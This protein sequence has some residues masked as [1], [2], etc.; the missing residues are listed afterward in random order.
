MPSICNHVDRLEASGLVTRRQGERDR[1]RV[2]LEVTAE[3]IRVLQAIRSKRTAWLSARLNALTDVGPRRHRGRHRAARGAPGAAGMSLGIGSATA[4]TFTS[5][6]RHYNYRLYFFGQVVSISGTWMQSVAQAWFVVQNTHSPL[7]VGI[8]AVC[9]FG[10]YALLGLFG[11]AVAD[12]LDQRKVLLGTQA[13][14]MITATLLAVLTLTGHATV[15]EVYVIAAI[16]GTITVVDNPVR[17]AFTIQMVGRDELPNAVALNSSLFNA[18]RIVGPAIAGGLIA[19][20]GVG[21]CFLINALSY[22]AVLAALWM[23]RVHDL[24]PTTP[25]SASSEPVPRIDRGSE[26]RVAHTGDPLGAR[27]DAVHRDDQHQLQRA[28]A[29]PRIANAA[30]RSAGLR[31]PLGTVRIRRAPWRPLLGLAGSCEPA[32]HARRR[33]ALLCSPSLYSR[34]STSSGPRASHS[35]G[36]GHRVHASTP[37]QTNATLQLAVTDQLRGRVLGIYGYVFFGTAPTRWPPRRA[38]S[39]QSAGPSWRSWSPALTGARRDHLRVGRHRPR[40]PRRA[41]ADHA[42]RIAMVPSLHPSR[43]GRRTGQEDVDVEQRTLGTQ[44]L[45]VSAIGLGCMGM[46]DFYGTAEDRNEG[47]ALATIDRAAELGVTLL[48]TADMYG[49][50]TNEELVGRALIGSPR[51][52]RGRHEVRP[53]ASAAGGADDQRNA[54]VRASRV[55]RIAATARHRHDRPLLP[56]P[57][58]SLGAHRGDG[59]CDG[60]AGRTRARFA[61]SG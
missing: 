32:R 27:D 23:M 24:F 21:I 19:V 51:S 61:A 9:Q 54:R 7:A 14:F 30:Q 10:P 25:R 35:G 38:G 45:E 50:F 17:Q 40:G 12:R 60:G 53:R 36:H 22:L 33:R 18:S 56:A 37:S 43:A 4:R 16:T 39:P 47:E 58:R 5:L 48:D 49:P 44:G 13:A 28:A 34:R 1:R 59:R 2:D 57:C 26:V 52:V 20:A 11:G 41:P 3:G 6:R 55:R 46:S 15:W 29:R 42:A 8:L 31:H